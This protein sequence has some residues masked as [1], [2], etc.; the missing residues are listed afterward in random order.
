MRSHARVRRHS[1]STSRPRC[2]RN[3]RK[4]AYGHAGV[5]GA[6]GLIPD[7]AH[8]LSALKD[9]VETGTVPADELLEHYNT[10]WAGDLTRIYAEYS[11]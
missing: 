6:D 7:E 2:P 3:W 10:D 1:H 11:Y 9:S 8:F 4:R 5:K